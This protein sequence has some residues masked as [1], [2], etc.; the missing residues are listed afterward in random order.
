MDK[1]RTLFY[2]NELKSNILRLTKGTISQ[3][4]ASALAQQAIDVLDWS[5]SALQHKGF[6]WIA[7]KLLEKIGY[8]F[9]YTT[10]AYE[11]N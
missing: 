5:N 4:E 11:L 10:K 9:N 7:G 3:H 2:E 8:S 6:G 1:S